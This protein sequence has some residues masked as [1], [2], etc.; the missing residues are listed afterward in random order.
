MRE[1][2]TETRERER[3][4]ITMAAVDFIF[5]FKSMVYYRKGE[6]GGMSAQMGKGFFCF[7]FVFSTTEAATLRQGQD[8][9]RTR[10]LSIQGQTI[11]IEKKLKITIKTKVS[12]NGGEGQIHCDNTYTHISLGIER[13]LKMHGCGVLE[14]D[15]TLDG[16]IPFV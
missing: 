13:A 6:L 11:G 14:R 3:K 8:D 16:M 15:I 4:K 7:C 2:V 10:T 9:M 12:E 1:N 5:Q